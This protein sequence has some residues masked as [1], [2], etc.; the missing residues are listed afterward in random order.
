MYFDKKV[1]L[2]TGSYIKGKKHGYGEMRYLNGDLYK[3]NWV[4]DHK[5][6]E[7]ATYYSVEKQLKSIGKAE[8]GQFIEISRQ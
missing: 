2:F 8:H 1:G 6:S 5:E 3:G 4:E 7:K